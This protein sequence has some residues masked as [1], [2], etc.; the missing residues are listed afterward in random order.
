MFPDLDLS[1]VLDSLK[2]VF[3]AGKV[4]ANAS[5]NLFLRIWDFGVEVFNAI[6][7]VINKLQ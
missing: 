4:F 7:G 6:K 1:P 5:V 3:N 2:F